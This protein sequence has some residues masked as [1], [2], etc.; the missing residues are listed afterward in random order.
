MRKV[1]NPIF[2]HCCRTLETPDQGKLQH[3][4]E[5]QQQQPS[6]DCK[7]ENPRDPVGKKKN[8][9]IFEF[10]KSNRLSFW[11]SSALPR[12]LCN[13]PD[14]RECLAEREAVKS[15]GR[16]QRTPAGPARKTKTKFTLPPPPHQVDLHSRFPEG[17]VGHTPLHLHE[18]R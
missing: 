13:T 1:N 6:D 16:T 15:E 9:P 17:L 4:Q 14:V 5:L 3:N 8:G 7:I 11:A 2:I 10:S 12:Y 18:T